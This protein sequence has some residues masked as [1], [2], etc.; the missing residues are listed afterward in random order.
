MSKEGA[1]LRSLRSNE[2]LRN[3]D[4][5]EKSELLSSLNDQNAT[6]APVEKN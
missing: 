1:L 5:N 3:P 2:G 6:G 4:S